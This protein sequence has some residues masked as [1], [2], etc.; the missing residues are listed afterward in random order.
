MHLNA[1]SQLT[2]TMR[3]VW[4]GPL[5]REARHRSQLKIGGRLT[6]SFVGIVLLM[7]AADAVALWQFDLVRGQAQRI[8][9]VDQK[10]VAVLRVQS[11]LWMLRDKLEG[12]VTAQDA[13]RFT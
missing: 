5:F 4:D 8:Y 3:S 6:L 12:L 13:P 10:S 11:N 9:N 1:I 2:K 7:V